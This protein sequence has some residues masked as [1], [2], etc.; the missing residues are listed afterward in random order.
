LTRPPSALVSIATVPSTAVAVFSANLDFESLADAVIG[1]IPEADRA[2]LANFK[3]VA[4][5]LL[6]GHDPLTWL[7]PRLGSA[8]MAYLEVEANPEARPSFPWVAAVGWQSREGLDDLAGPIDNALRTLF[9]MVAFDQKSREASIKVETR[10]LAEGRLT[11]LLKGARVLLAYRTDHQRLVLGN[12]AE[13]VA[14]FATGPPNPT[15]VELRAK[16]AA[17]AETFALVDVERL[18]GE[19]KR[20]QSPIARRLAAKSHRPVEATER[21][22]GQVIDLASLFRAFAFSTT[23]SKDATEIHRSMGLIAR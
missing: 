9:A 14:R 2:S 19:I 17:E 3:L 20:L 11:S 8:T 6:L 23:T 18:V 16:Y 4:Q 1:Q 22:L 13:A 5:G 12:S 15:L 7:L 10:P 21:D